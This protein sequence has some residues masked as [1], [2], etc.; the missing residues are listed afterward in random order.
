MRRR[1]PSIVAR[2]NERCRCSLMRGKLFMI[3]TEKTAV[4]EK[5]IAR[6]KIFFVITLFMNSVAQTFSL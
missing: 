6:K 2:V 1:F 5:A 3:A 4:A